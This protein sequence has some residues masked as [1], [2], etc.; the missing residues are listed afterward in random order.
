METNDV[1]ELSKMADAL[2]LKFLF[3][4]LFLPSTTMGYFITVEAHDEQCFYD[5]VA[6][7]TKMGL[8][9]EVAEGGFRDIDVTVRC[10]HVSLVYFFRLYC[11]PLSSFFLIISGKIFCCFRSYMSI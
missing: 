4:F 10:D 5:K 7:G 11:T 9:F 3:M 2:E 6:S 8:L 1:A